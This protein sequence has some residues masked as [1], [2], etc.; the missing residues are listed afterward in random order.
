MYKRILALVSLLA[1]AAAA[2]AATEAYTIDPVHSSLGFTIRHLVSKVPGRFPKF[3]GTINVDR[4]NLANSSV[5]ATIEVG[6]VNTENEKR[7]GHLMSA[8][9][10]DVAKFPTA[11]FKSKSW[12]KTG[13]DTYD[14]TGDLTIKGV[15]KE[16]VLHVTSLGFAPGM[17]PGT[18]VSG[19]EATGAIKKSDFGVSGP[20]M[21]G[22]VLGDDVAISISIE[23][24]HQAEAA[25]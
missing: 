23:A 7:N 21:L 13:E 5:E 17:K 3:T 16:T 20:A 18:T 10:F 1:L 15:T 11:S 24:G 2:H 19:W 12:S 22:K 9:F 8:D 25:K 6:S 4:A 14:V